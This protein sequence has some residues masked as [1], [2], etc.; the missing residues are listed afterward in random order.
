ME[1]RPAHAII[2]LAESSYPWDLF[3]LADP[4][5]D[6]IE[7]YISGAVVLGAFRG[8]VVVGAIILAPIHNGS[9]ERP[10]GNY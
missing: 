10:E 7:G 6:M 2:P 3:L 4:S 1:P 8:S 5:R 9:W